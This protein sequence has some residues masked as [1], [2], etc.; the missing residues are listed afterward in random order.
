MR[1][2]VNKFVPMTK[3]LPHNILGQFLLNSVDLEFAQD[4]FPGAVTQHSVDSFTQ[5]AQDH[6]VSVFSVTRLQANMAKFYF[7]DSQDQ[8]KFLEYLKSLS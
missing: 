6:C 5:W 4:Y 1:Y 2:F 3:E 7:F 8:S